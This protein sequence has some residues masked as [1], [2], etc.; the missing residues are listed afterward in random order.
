[1]QN[2]VLPICLFLIVSALTCAASH[3]PARTWRVWTAGQLLILS[4]L[5]WIWRGQAVSK[6]EVTGSK[7]D[8]TSVLATFSSISIEGP[9]RQ[10]VFHY[11]LQNT[12]GHLFRVESNA[13]SMVSLRFVGN[14]AEPGAAREPNPALNLLENQGASY[15]KFTGLERIPTAT[16]ALSL[17]PCPLE[18]QPK[19]RREVSIAIPYAY[20][21]SK[22]PKPGQAD[23][24]GYVRAFMPRIDGFGMSDWTRNYEIIFPREW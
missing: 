13:C 22:G 8:R 4:V 6:A 19:P 20:P 21:K 12:T 15:S 17:N 9:Q 3:A 16:P 5:F 23:L 1:M 7:V 14:I 2:L 10:L 24:R 18:L 11:T